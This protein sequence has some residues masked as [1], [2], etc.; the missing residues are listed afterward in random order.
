MIE[1]QL[2]RLISAMGRLTA[3]LEASGAKP[4]VAPAQSTVAKSATVEPKSAPAVA[5]SV[6]DESSAP[7]VAPTAPT[8][9]VASAPV[10]TVAPTASAGTSAAPAT[11]PADPAPATVTLEFLK[12]RCLECSKL[13]KMAVLQEFLISKTAKRIQDLAPDEFAV[14]YQHLL[15]KGACSKGD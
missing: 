3:A 7:A 1:D 9:A 8:V 15:S 12:A 4:T 6:M 11:V 5:P 14:C 13:G 10:D 2:E